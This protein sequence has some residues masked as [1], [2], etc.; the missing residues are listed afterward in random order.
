VPERNLR[1]TPEK[2]SILAL[3]SDSFRYTPWSAKVLFP[4]RENARKGE[5][6]VKILT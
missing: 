3:I 5:W 2:N 4:D 1:K 6:R